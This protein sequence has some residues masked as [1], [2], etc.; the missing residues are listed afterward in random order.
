MIISPKISIKYPDKIV[1]II[2]AGIAVVLPR[3]AALLSAYPAFEWAR[4]L[5]IETIKTRVRDP[6]TASLISQSNM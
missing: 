1:P 2:A 3:L 6:I 5:P 4:L